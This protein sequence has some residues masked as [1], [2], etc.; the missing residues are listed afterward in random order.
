MPENSYIVRIY[1]SREAAGVI[2]AD[3]LDTVP[4]T[5]KINDVSKDKWQTFHNKDELWTLITQQETA[6]EEA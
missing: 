3:D 2:T 5:G 4:V 6:E 1:R